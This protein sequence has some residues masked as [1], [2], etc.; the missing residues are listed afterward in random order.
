MV[1]RKVLIAPMP[2][3]CLICFCHIYLDDDSRALELQII[4]YC[5]CSRRGFVISQWRRY[6]CR[7]SSLIICHLIDKFLAKTIWLER[8]GLLFDFGKCC[9][10]CYYYDL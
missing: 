8:G 10:V 6:R 5:P 7:L 4:L 9:V 1:R 2:F 3:C